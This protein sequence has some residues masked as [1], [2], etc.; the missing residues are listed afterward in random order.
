MD[1]KIPSLDCPANEG[2]TSKNGQI[3]GKMGHS[4]HFEDGLFK[5]IP[6]IKINISLHQQFNTTGNK[7]IQHD[8]Q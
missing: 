1:S 6:E 7:G 8:I 3:I 4:E 2:I 5:S